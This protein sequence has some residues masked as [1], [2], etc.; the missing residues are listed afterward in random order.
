MENENK[1]ELRKHG[2]AAN[3]MLALSQSDLA[4]IKQIRISLAQALISIETLLERSEP[5]D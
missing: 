2:S 1:E 3:D 4:E 5:L